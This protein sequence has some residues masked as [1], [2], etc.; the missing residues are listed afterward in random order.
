MVSKAKLY[1]QLDS[2]EDELRERIVPHL[3]NAAKGGNELIFCTTDFNPFQKLKYRADSETDALIQLGGQILVLRDKLG[4]P[5]EGTIAERICWYCRKWGDAGENHQKAVQ[6]LA[7]D[8]LRE[9][10]NEKT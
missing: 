8:F 4:E 9:V 2:M 6:A 1:S 10:I 7:Q 3:E 5:T